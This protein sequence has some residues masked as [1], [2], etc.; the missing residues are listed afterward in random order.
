[1]KTYLNAAAF[2]GLSMLS[3]SALTVNIDPSRYYTFIDGKHDPELIPVGAIVGHLFGRFPQYPSTLSF[4]LD[5]ARALASTAWDIC[6]HRAGSSERW[7]ALKTPENLSDPAAAGRAAMA[8]Q[9]AELEFRED[10]WVSAQSELSEEALRQLEDHIEEDILPVI[11]H[12]IVD[13]ETMFTEQRHIFDNFRSTPQETRPNPQIS[14][15][16]AAPALMDETGAVILSGGSFYPDRNTECLQ[17]F[18]VWLEPALAARYAA[19]QGLDL[20]L[21]GIKQFAQDLHPQSFDPA[22]AE[23]SR[24]NMLAMADALESVAAG[25]TPEE[26]Y[27]R[28]ALADGGLPLKSWRAM[29]QRPYADRIMQF[30]ASA[31]EMYPELMLEKAAAEPWFRY[32]YLE[33]QL[34]DRSEAPEC[35]GGPLQPKQPLCRQRLREQYLEYAELQ[36]PNAPPG[37]RDLLLLMRMSG[38]R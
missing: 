26:A 38:G 36:V 16:V 12:Q 31:A 24:V 5:D 1:M 9:I 7:E 22:S 23:Q 17:T 35:D 34:G 3:S 10:R 13:Y 19:D 28:H 27:Q 15:S 6:Q 30:R 33:A 21:D 29:A 8:Y 11:R 20:S 4:E 25:D 14:A 2:L 37:W 32:A 18:A